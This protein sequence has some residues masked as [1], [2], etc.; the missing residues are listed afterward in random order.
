MV[1]ITATLAIVLTGVSSALPQLLPNY[2][3]WLSEA[4]SSIP[5]FLR[6]LGG[7]TAEAQFFKTELGGLG[8]L[9]GGW[10]AHRA[11]KR[12][13]RWAGFPISYGTGLWPWIVGSALLGLLLSDLVWGWTSVVTGT[14]QPTF[15]PFVSV[16]PAIVLVY[17]AGWSVAVTG[18]VLGAALTTPIALLAVNFVCHP[19]GLP[20]VTGSVTGMWGGALIAFLLARRLPWMQPPGGDF[21]PDTPETTGQ[22]SAPAGTST[23]PSQHGPGWV[24]RR[25]LADFTEA[26]FHGNEIAAIGLIAGTVLSYV[27]NRLTPVYGSGLLPAVLT[28]QVLTAT[29]GVLLYHRRWV[30]AGSYPTFVPVVSV[31]PA[32]VLTYGPTVQAIV[33]GA[34]LGAIAG[35]PLAA[36]LS[37]RLPPDFH[38]FIGNVLSMTICTL[39][40][41]PQLSIL[42]GFTAAT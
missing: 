14:A 39:T 7:E 17:G 40:I 16:P 38:P 33:V 34:V 37:K 2:E 23:A 41:I 3:S 4:Y 32:T 11:W 29:L 30:E 42:P 1:A 19:L 9:L 24:V 18:A 6:W 22:Q 21:S 12:G 5:Q 20:A 15:V 27:L 26:P 13:R 10:V 8:M 36:Q 28:A 31:A 35:P 25:V